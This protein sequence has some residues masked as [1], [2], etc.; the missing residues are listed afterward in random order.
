[1]G[2][3]LIEA[4]AAGL[5]LVGPAVGGVGEAMLNGVTGL[6]VS[7]RSPKSFAAAVLQ[8]LNDPAWR[9]RA[10]AKGPRFVARQFGQERMVHKI[11]R[12]YSKSSERSWGSLLPRF[13]AG[14][15]RR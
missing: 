4:Q 1:L 3:V 15:H 14:R 6:L 11:I 9:K 12:I 5:P 7:D 2:L 8:V 10:A 13:L